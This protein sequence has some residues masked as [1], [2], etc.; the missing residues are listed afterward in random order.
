MSFKNVTFSHDQL[1]VDFEVIEPAR[2]F[3]PAA[4]NPGIVPLSVDDGQGRVSVGR[5][6]QQLEPGRAP[7]DRRSVLGG[8]DGVRASGHGHRA[9]SPAELQNAVAFVILAGQSHIVSVEAKDFDGAG[10][11]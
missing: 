11:H 3:H 8:E 6:A 10:G 2:D 9:S 4:K 1:N 7:E 5:P